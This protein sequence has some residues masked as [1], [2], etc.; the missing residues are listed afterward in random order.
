MRPRRF[1]INCATIKPQH[2]D[3]LWPKQYHVVWN[4]T[5]NIVVSTPVTGIHT[6]ILLK[7][8]TPS[9]RTTME[10][11]L[12]PGT[13]LIWTLT[14]LRGISTLKFPSNLSEFVLV[15]PLMDLVYPLES[16]KNSVLEL[17]TS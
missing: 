14:K 6:R 1:G 7:C 4:L 2:L 12:M 13:L 10:S 8:S 15:A 17:R 3:L 5:T 9:S 11:A 16:P